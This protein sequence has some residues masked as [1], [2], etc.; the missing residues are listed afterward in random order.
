[1]APQD[2]RI[3]ALDIGTKT[4]GIAAT[5]PLGITVQP[6]TTLRYKGDRERQKLFQKLKDILED[7]APQKIVV[8]LPVRADESEGSQAKWVKEFVRG[9]QNHLK[10]EH[11]DSEK[12]DW[13]FWDERFTTDEAEKFLIA[14][15]VSR[16][17]RK[18]VIDKMAAVFILR[19]Y[20]EE[21]G[22]G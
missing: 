13:I 16:K 12:Y 15:D 19:S 20:L 17:K 4:I 6:L 14:Q 1:M 9:F 10:R 7:L 5:D 3:L 8:G 22:N 2:K 11:A 21:K 18:E